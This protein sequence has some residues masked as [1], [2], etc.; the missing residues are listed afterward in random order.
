MRAAHAAPTYIRP[1]LNSVTKVPH[2]W[3]EGKG[4]KGD[5]THLDPRRVSA[6]PGH[7]HASTLEL[8]SP[9]GVKFVVGAGAAVD[10]RV[11]NTA[12]AGTR[13]VSR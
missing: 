2:A 12:P 1:E 10:Q 8:A 11:L 3:R 7:G 6:M 4:S 5:G 9:P 13:P